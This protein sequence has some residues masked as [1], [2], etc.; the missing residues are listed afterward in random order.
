MGGAVIEVKPGDQHF[1]SRGNVTETASY[2]LLVS[3]KIRD[4]MCDP[5]ALANQE[6]IVFYVE[7]ELRAKEHGAI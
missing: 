6:N 7:T 2:G 4:G 5:S 1:G 3:S